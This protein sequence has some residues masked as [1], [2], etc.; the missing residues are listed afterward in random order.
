MTGMPGASRPSGRSTLWGAIST[1]ILEG[2][3]VAVLAV[4]GT[5]IAALM[6]LL[7]G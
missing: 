2:L 7:T 3:V 1:L 4:V 5:G 6:L